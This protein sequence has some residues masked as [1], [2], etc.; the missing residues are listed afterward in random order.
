[1]I[2]HQESLGRKVQLVVFAAI[3]STLV[4]TAAGLGF[5][6][7]RAAELRLRASLVSW[8]E[9]AHEQLK[10]ALTFGYPDTAAL[11]L[12]RVEASPAIVAARVY[13]R[14]GPAGA[15]PFA[16][17]V[18]PGVPPRFAA[19]ERPDGSVVDGGRML[20]VVSFPPGRAATATLQL[21][22]DLS[23]ARADWYQSLRW[24]LVV[25]AVLLAI[26][27]WLAQSLERSVT[28]PVLQ[29]LQTARRVHE[30]GDYGLRA[31]I[32]TRDEVG[33]LAVQ[34]NEMLHGID[35]RDRTIAESA[36]FQSAI[37]AGSGV[38][39]ISC[40]PDGVVVT[41]NPAAERLLGYTA[42]E[43]VG[44]AVTPQWH[45]PVEVQ[46]RAV[47]FS[48]L[49]GA[50]VS[51]G[52][53]TLIALARVKGSDA[54]EWTFVCRDGTRVPVW[55]VV[56]ALRGSTGEIIGYV[57]LASDLR[58][59][60]AAEEALRASED[61]FRRLAESSMVGVFV[62]ADHRILYS[63]PR[64]ATILG[65]ESPDE[66]LGLSWTEQI[67]P[68]YR[69]EIH[70]RADAVLQGE[71]VP[72][73]EGFQLRRKDGAVVWLQ[74]GPTRISWDG[75][76]AI[77]SFVIDITERKHVEEAL[78]AS[79]ERHRIVIEQTGQMVYD[80][81]IL[82][83]RNL[84]FGAAAVRNIT[85]HTLPEFQA[86]TFQGWADLI[87]PEDRSAALQEFERCLVSGEAYDVLYRF[88]HKD[89]SYRWVTDVG[90][91]LRDGA[92]RI[93]RMLGAMSDVTARHAA[94]MQ[95]RQ[96]ERKF[97][98]IF[99]QSPDLIMLLRA[100]DGRL[101]DVNSAFLSQTGWSR[102]E[103]LGRTPVEL[104][105]CAHA[106]VCELA[107]AAATTTGDH[108]LEEFIWLDRERKL[109]VGR[110]SLRR[111]E[112]GGEP[113]INGVLHDITAQRR[114]EQ[115]LRSY[116]ETTAGVTG[117]EFFGAVVKQMCIELG[118]RYALLGELIEGEPPKIRT[119]AAWADGR[120]AEMEYTLA[121]TPCAEVARDGLCHYADGVA[122]LF[123]Q[124][125]LLGR[126]QVR[127]YAGMPIRDH[128]GKTRGLIA[129]LDDKPMP[130]AAAASL[131]L[132]LSATRAAAEL[133]RMHAAAEILRL[134]ADLERRV[135]GRTAELAQRVAEVE[136]LN[137][138]QE[139]L[140]V[141][142]RSSQQAADRSAARLQ[143]VNASLL[144]ANQELESFSYTVS[145][146]LRA[147]LRNING[148]M[149]LL[150]NRTTGRLDTEGERFISVVGA[151]SRRM[152]QLIDDLLTF[153]R[154]GRTELSINPV[155]L[156][157]LLEEV[158]AELEPEIRG[159]Q[160]EWR[161]TPLPVV[162]GDRTLLR[163]ILANLLGNAV[164]FTRRRT[165]AIIEVG[166]RPGRPGDPCV[167]IFVRDNGDF[168]GTGIGLA[169]VKRIVTRHGGRIW[170]EGKPEEGAT[171]SFTLTPA[172]ERLMRAAP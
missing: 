82:S 147:P 20:L 17:W 84:W 118:V 169:N 171:F 73:H 101:L 132:V 50:K 48:S 29:L 163:Q 80:L 16:S 63:N 77:H 159:R 157:A 46:Q 76:P 13:A 98:T 53:E 54:R 83:G 21:E 64:F 110:L 39:V 69:E 151:E 148:F 158:Q 122:E 137:R 156:T 117:Q 130:D 58:E 12:K 134:N 152:G 49:T 143:E 102:G 144:A 37:L 154:I 67:L 33:Q 38:A 97:A 55:L 68:E 36:A 95:L 108:R 81:D 166:A 89:G 150:R 127:S 161:V 160:I 66:L 7:Y 70:R 91:F 61:R 94:E 1:M 111:I 34:F 14:P 103:V 125:L 115:A 124:D 35:G 135:Q 153:S 31:E 164:K 30:T 11:A 106:E 128:T 56:S 23:A 138:E 47:E 45:D 41:F 172:G 52:F 165:P 25:F 6:E 51:P 10:D 75:R 74:T 19:E 104:G 114:Q 131:L 120:P 65:V 72:V 9:I 123:P 133:Q 100:A 121:D 168:E 85:G 99:E 15:N 78:R 141:D 116:S 43:V 59:R 92:G 32:A 26:G 162:L 93:F 3:C 129:I 139:A 5:Y 109:H 145:H 170:A 105:F 107:F 40:R 8:A 24:L 44:R 142:L 27:W 90:V 126:M 60:K 22:G 79:E 167:T 112:V 4:L 149:E 57:G 136:R 96:S 86:V 140:V 18:R 87:H 71:K 113:V 2:A 155:A 62:T 88:Q 146:D 42:A 28:R 119:L